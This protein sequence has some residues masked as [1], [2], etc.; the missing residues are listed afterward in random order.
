[1]SEVNLL[2]CRRTIL[3]RVLLLELTLLVFV[4]GCKDPKRTDQ[5]REPTNA[6]QITRTT[7][8]GA[9][10]PSAL[11]ASPATLASHSKFHPVPLDEFYQRQFVDY[12]PSDSWAQVPRGET[13]FDGVPFLMFGK[14]DLTGLGRARYGEFQPARV[15]E[16]PVGQRAT[17]LHLVH[18]AS[19]DS[20]EG[21]PIACLLLR[22]ENSETQKLFLRYGVHARNWYVEPNELESDL[23][24]PHSLVV[25]RGNSRPDGSGKPTRLFKT[26]FDNP[27][28]GQQIRAL[29]LLSLFARAN[30]VILAVT[31]EEA[32]EQAKPG[33]ADAE[34]NDDSPYR[35]E[36]SVRVLDADTGLPIPNVILKLSVTEAART[37]RF[38][39]YLSDAR[40]QIHI[41]Y[42]PRKFRTF[43]MDLTTP[44][45]SPVNFEVSS[46][47]GLFGPDLPVRLKRRSAP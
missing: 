12:R 7:T 20:P 40:G 23:S 32:S 28:P 26:T 1:M 39:T 22:Y 10:A 38:G 45:Y 46:D 27:R 14:I 6:E 30:A 2:E 35:R 33:T 9:P 47:D 8:P 34:D 15:G 36:D 16:I 41:I 17:R 25:W 4:T 37:Y 19:Y 3:R 43:S 24:D 11:T 13:N 31:L 29:E 5:A 18:G 44:D 21:T 42:P